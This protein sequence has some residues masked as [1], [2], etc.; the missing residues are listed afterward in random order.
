MEVVFA[1][2]VKPFDAAKQRLAAV[3]SARQRRLTTMAMASRIVAFGRSAGALPLVLA[4]DAEVDAWATS[5][6][7]DSLLDVGSNLDEAARG[8]TSWARSRNAGWVICHADLP[9]LLPGDLTNVIVA[10][11][12]GRSF[13]T[14]S[15]DGGTTILGGNGDDFE[16]EYGSA[17]FHRHLRRLNNPTVVSSIALSL[18]LDGPGD[19]RAATS[20]RRG[21][22]LADLLASNAS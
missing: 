20:H 8:A 14:P 1:V 5:H 11:A 15:T 21:Q 16:F 10:V 18:D 3:L 6:G 4:A 2:P 9:L 7:V 13:I 12:Q 19:L 17:S 22:W